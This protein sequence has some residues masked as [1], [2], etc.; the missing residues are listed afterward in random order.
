MSTRKL[1]AKCLRVNHFARRCRMAKAY[2]FSGCGQRHH[3]LLHPPP[4]AAERVER[5]AGCTS[6]ESLL[7]GNLQNDPGGAGQEAQCAAVKSG[8]SRVS[9]QIVP[10]K[11]CGPEIETYAFLDNGS[12][13]TLCLSSLAE[14]LGVSGKPVHFSLSSVNAENIPKSGYE[15]SLNVFSLDGNEPILLDR[16]WTVD[17]L[18]LSKRSIRS[19]E[20]VSQWP[21]LESIKFPRLG[22]EE[23]AVSIR[24]GNDVGRMVGQKTLSTSKNIIHQWVL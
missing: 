12:D 2:L 1:C 7:E 20:D 13:T 23:K 8:R 3:S 14:S 17:C 19:D 9:L 22:G 24:T 16:V 18:P 10:M 15:V 5:P 21:H 11:V 4:R 6:Q